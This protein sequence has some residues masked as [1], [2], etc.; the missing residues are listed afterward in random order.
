MS[1][2]MATLMKTRL[3]EGGGEWYSY[4]SAWYK[5]LFETSSISHPGALD[6]AQLFLLNAP[7]GGGDMERS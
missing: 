1:A 5:S 3:E 7:L 4:V 2:G 6:P